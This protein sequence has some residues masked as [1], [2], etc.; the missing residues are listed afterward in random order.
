MGAWGYDAL[1]S[2]QALDWLANEVTD[3]VGKRVEAV[4]RGCSCR[5]CADGRIYE[6]RAAAVGRLVRAVPPLPPLLRRQR[7]R[8]ARTEQDALPAWTPVHTRQHLHQPTR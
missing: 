1:D 8:Q 7:A 6:L 3:H 4:L 2:D 5:E